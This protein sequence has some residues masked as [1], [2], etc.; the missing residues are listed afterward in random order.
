LVVLLLAGVPGLRA[1]AFSVLYNFSTG[2]GGNP[3]AGLVQ[4]PA[5]VFYGTTQ[6]GGP[7][8]K[9]SVFALTSAG[10][11]TFTYTE[12]HA[13]SGT[14][15]QTP[16]ARLLLASDGDLYGTTSSGGAQSRGTVFRMDTSGNLTTLRSFSSD[17]GDNGPS[18][19][20]EGQDGAFYGTCNSGGQANG[21]GTFFRIDSAGNLTVLHDF[22]GDE[23]GGGPIGGVVLG[24][25][26]AFYGVCVLGGAS[27]N[28]VVFRVDGMGAYSVIH[29]FVAADGAPP[30]AG[31]VAAGDGFL[32]GGTQF[33]GANDVGTIFRVDTSGT[34]DVVYDFAPGD[35]R[36]PYSDLLD[37][38]DGYL[39]GVNGILTNVNQGTVFRVTPG[40]SF[41]TIHTF[42]EADD[43]PAYGRPLLAAD[44]KI[45]GTA[46]GNPFAPGEGFVYRMDP[47]GGSFEIVHPFS[48]ADPSAP[49]ALL[50]ASDGFFYGSSG[51]G[52]GVDAGTVYRFDPAAGVTVL[53]AFSGPDGTGP[54]VLVEGPDHALYGSTFAGGPVGPGI[55]P[56]GVLFRVDT[57]GSFS[58]LHAFDGT[59]GSTPS[60]LAVAPDDTFFGAT[61]QGG[62]GPGTLFHLDPGLAFSSIHD[63]DFDDGSGPEGPLVWSNGAAYGVT[64]AG[65]SNQAGTLFRVDEDGAG[66]FTSVRSFTGS[67]GHPTL[68]RLGLYGLLYGIG[69]TGG[70]TGYGTLFRL[71]PDGS[72]GPVHSFA[73]T[74]DGGYPT[75]LLL[76]MD[77]NFYGVTS[78]GTLFRADPSGHVVTLHEFGGADGAEPLGGLV[79][80]PDGDLYGTTAQGGLYGGGVIFR[81]T[82]PPAPAVWLVQPSSGPAAA[83]TAI[84]IDGAGFQ[85]VPTVAVGGVAATDVVFQSPLLVTATTPPLDPG[86][87]NDLMLTNP[88]DSAGG[89]TA[90]WFADFLDVPQGDLFHAAVESV[91]RFGVTAGCGAG[92][93]C[94]NA[95]MTRAQMA[96]F[97]LKALLG[98]AY[99]PPPP[100]GTLFG[101]VPADAFAAAWIED[102]ANRGIAAGCGS[103]NYC[104]SAPVTRAQMAPLL[105]RA[106]FGGSYTPP[107]ASGTVFGD[108]PVDGFAADWIEDLARRGITAG[109]SVSPPL[110]CP[111]APNTRGQM[112]VFVV[113]TFQL[114]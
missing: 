24:S 96:V 106:R 7:S 61:F 46:V 36:M 12:L 105:L 95:P 99:V 64:Y 20:I 3:W 32:Y 38:G 42:L 39:Y 29:D 8:G 111:D 10:G 102:I 94:R 54:G 58:L 34:L 68:V 28:G 114:L 88:D 67:E 4:T 19:L 31:L 69:Y 82:P 6:T 63:F 43:G 91:F 55:T 1:Q 25:D 65:G 84:S 73:G 104:P 21:G 85:E 75:G 108:V 17:D 66:A 70:G 76:G 62:P 35:G 83:P 44:G 18:K 45:Y 11:G 92:N 30:S 40:G 77:G 14:D 52:G 60:G 48:N 109:C 97:L 22:A 112:A 41:E 53:H 56:R 57:A 27:G 101:D 100:L 5:G 90:A 103:G 15:G 26:G 79:Q 23:T 113:R 87:L 89:Y 37:G 2:Q 72:G 78:L 107:A 110:Y 13:F 98:P 59:D 80:A 86:T 93:Y 33:G 74:G 51:M 49:N 81:F 50:L 9:G 71:S 47:D 16:V